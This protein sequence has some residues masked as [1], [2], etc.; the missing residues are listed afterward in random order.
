MGSAKPPEAPKPTATTATRRG[1]DRW[2]REAG[3]GGLGQNFPGF[4]GEAMGG[5]RR[6][7]TRIFDQGKDRIYN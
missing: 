3:W 2:S 4:W 1:I 5:H 6:W 7:E